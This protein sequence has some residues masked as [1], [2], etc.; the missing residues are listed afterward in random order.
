MVPFAQ[1]LLRQLKPDALRSSGDEHGF[2]GDG[3]GHSAEMTSA[4]YLLKDLQRAVNTRETR[5]VE[6]A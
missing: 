4:K 6:E 1:Q 3:G 2:A 5:K